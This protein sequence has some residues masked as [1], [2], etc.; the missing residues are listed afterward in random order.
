M[1]TLEQG[2]ASLYV[3]GHGSVW[4]VDACRNSGLNLEQ[5]YTVLLCAL[6]WNLSIVDT[7]G[8]A[9]VAL[10]SGYP[11]LKDSFVHNS[12]QLVTPRQCPE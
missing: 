11:H 1:L 12:I 2:G 6:Q 4:I 7:Q 9:D 8:T 10:I 3:H 5:H